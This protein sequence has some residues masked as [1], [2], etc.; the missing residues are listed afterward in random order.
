[1]NKNTTFQSK[2][3]QILFF[4]CQIKNKSPLAR[5]KSEDLYVYEVDVNIRRVLNVRLNEQ[6][7]ISKI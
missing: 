2:S 6:S 7:N 4:P 5:T 1:M 3:N